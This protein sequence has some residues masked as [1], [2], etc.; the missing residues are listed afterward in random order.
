MKNNFS[1]KVRK[2]QDDCIDVRV[3]TEKNEPTRN[4]IKLSRQDW[5][6]C[7]DEILEMC[8]SPCVDDDLLEEVL[9]T[10][11]KSSNTIKDKLA[12]GAF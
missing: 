3:Y 6:N 8:K 7:L 5:L 12:V 9:N 4:G 11:I 1:F 10:S 2:T